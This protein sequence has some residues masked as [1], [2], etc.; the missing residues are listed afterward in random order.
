MEAYDLTKEKIVEWAIEYASYEELEE[1]AKALYSQHKQR[2]KAERPDEYI[3]AKKIKNKIK[4]EQAKQR[5]IKRKEA[6][7]AKTY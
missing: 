2:Q 4:R 1:V 6:R 5:K 3:N 7:L